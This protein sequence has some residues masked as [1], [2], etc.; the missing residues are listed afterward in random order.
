MAKTRLYLD[1]R[2]KAKDGLFPLVILISAGTSTSHIPTGIRLKDD[3]WNWHDIIKQPKQ[4]SLQRIVQTKL[5]D[6]S[7]HISLMVSSGKIKG[8][9]ASEIKRSIL[10][11]SLASE[12]VSEKERTFEDYFIQRFIKLQS[13][14]NTIDLYNYSFRLLAKFTDM[15]ALTFSMID[16]AFL[17]DFEAFLSITSDVNTRAIHFRNIRAIYNS[18][19]DDNVASLDDDPFRRFKIKT[20]PTLKRSLTL[21]EFRL[22]RD[23]PCKKHQEK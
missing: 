9:K 17:K 18:A 7:L 23:Y 16:V 21:D 13:N 19:I 3:K 15:K 20:S 12:P 11:E 22:L 1:T 4:G 14:K 6:I 2:K 8:L 10:S 5:S